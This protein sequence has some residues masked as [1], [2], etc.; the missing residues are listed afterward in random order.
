M[1]VTITLNPCIDKST[2]AEK[3]FPE[4]KL[5]CSS[6]INEP[7]GGGINVSKALKKLGETATAVFPAG[8]HNGEMLKGLLKKED[9]PFYA[10]P[11]AHETRE[12]WVILETQTNN[13]YRLTFPGENTN[14]ETLQQVITK[15]KELKP[16]II[17][18][19]GSL[20][21]GLPVNAFAQI[22]HT[23]KQL[24]SHYVLDTSG[25]ALRA[26][27]DV[28]VFLLK[29]NLSEL[30]RLI[31]KDK[32]N[33]EEVNEAANEIIQ[34]GYAEAVA[35]SLGAGGALL[36]TGHFRERVIAPS[37]KKQSTV[38]AGDSMV[39]GMV[40]QLHKGKTFSE[41][42]RLGVSCGTAATMNPGTQ[43]FNPSDVYRLYE[44]INL[45]SGKAVTAPVS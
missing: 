36:V 29:P 39:A 15:L 23:A 43:L 30:S 20:P 5:R 2:T 6:M 37:V 10:L 21:P 13:Q 27:A 42:I 35:V 19:S 16:E 22:A 9:I 3:L 24:N 18:A 25:E 12:N 32:L 41:M 38:G 14:E 4:A 33:D 26:A 1:I 17:V 40:Y 11:A 8:G 31:G 34:K 7:G 44:E 45:Q 28:G